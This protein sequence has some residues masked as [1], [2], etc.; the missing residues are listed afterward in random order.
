M[1]E[2]S[3]ITLQIFIAYDRMQIQTKG[4]VYCSVFL[5]D[6]DVGG[7]GNTKQGKEEVLKE[8]EG[9]GWKLLSWSQ[10]RELGSWLLI[11][12]LETKS[13]SGAKFAF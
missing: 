8:D 5:G 12:C 7:A 3:S 11:G 6:D 2:S 1:P 13:Q 10:C 9:L 4:F